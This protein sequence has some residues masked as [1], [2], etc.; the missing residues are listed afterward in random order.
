MSNLTLT[1][2][3]KKI[4][5]LFLIV[6]SVLI[7]SS[8][9]TNDN[10]S[11]AYGNFE[12]EEII[13]SAEAT[14]KIVN[15]DI[16]EGMKVNAKQLVGIIDTVGLA[17][18]RE[19]LQASIGTLSTKVQNIPAQLNVLEEKKNN[20]LR[21]IARAVVL[22]KSETMPSKQLDDLKG[23]LA[24]TEK[25]IIA[26]KTQMATSNQ[27]LLSESNP[28]E[29]QIKD[30]NDKI[31]KSY[32]YS[33]INGTVLVKYAMQ[34]EVASYGKALFKIA[35][36]ENIIL[37]VYV[38]GAQLNKVKIGNEVEVLIDKNEKETEELSGKVTWI[39]DKAEF[40]PKIIQTKKERVNLVYAVK[41][42]VKNDGKLKI[43]MPGEVNFK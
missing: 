36:L 37:R 32:I 6:T 30:V 8:C 34:G 18:K 27:G 42:L 23:E 40:T 11:D 10:T 29:V 22:V 35:D 7:V 3:I 19:Q 20:L 14:G 16:Q 28:L 25:Q 43:G 38:D 39:S 1:S 17:I 33:P 9:N 2:I 21:E 41:V 4:I 26:T 12:A 24:V 31:A 5:S 15:L 13:V